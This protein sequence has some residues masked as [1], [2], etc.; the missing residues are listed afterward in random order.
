M[1]QHEGLYGVAVGVILVLTLILAERQFWPP[2]EA[3]DTDP[4]LR[5]WRII[6]T[7]IRDDGQMATIRLQHPRQPRIV[8]VLH[9]EL[10]S[11]SIF[12]EANGPDRGDSPGP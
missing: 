2:P 10:L 7:Q 12:E 5:E 1:K 11:M 8:A 9:Y 6:S 3:F 4:Q